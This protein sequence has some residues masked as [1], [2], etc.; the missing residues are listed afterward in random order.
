M[1]VEE[2]AQ[3]QR[4]QP[5][6]RHQHLHLE[7]GWP[8]Q[9]GCPPQHRGHHR[10]RL[11]GGKNLPRYLQPTTGPGL[12]GGKGSHSNQPQSKHLNVLLK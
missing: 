1:V 2:G 7:E 10:A 6:P 11:E 8:P 5:A 3:V 9:Q 12:E 4:S